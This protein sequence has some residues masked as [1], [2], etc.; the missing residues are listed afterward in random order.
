MGTVPR[1]SV[2]PRVAQGLLTLMCTSFYLAGKS[3]TAWKTLKN[4]DGPRTILPHPLD[5]A[6]VA[7]VSLIEWC[8]TSYHDAPFIRWRTSR[9][10]QNLSDRP[11]PFW[12]AIGLRLLYPPCGRP[13]QCVCIYDTCTNWRVERQRTYL[14]TFRPSARDPRKNSTR[15]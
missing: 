5:E 1:T 4:L 9:H 14:C 15:L 6:S 11:Q 13:W 10:M 3:V 12:T 7:P 8:V 2:G